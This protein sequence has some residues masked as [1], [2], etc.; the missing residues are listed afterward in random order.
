MNRACVNLARNVRA[1]ATGFDSPT[2]QRA[3]EANPARGAAGRLHPQPPLVPVCED[4]AD[5]QRGATGMLASDYRVISAGNVEAALAKA[6]AEP[7]DLVVMDL[8]MRGPGGVHLITEMRSRGRLAQIPVIVLAGSADEQSRFKLPAKWVQ[9]Y[10]TKPFSEEEVRGRVGVVMKCTRDALQEELARQSEDLSRLTEELIGS[11]QALKRSRK[12]ARQSERHLR[13][14]F[15]NSVTGVAIADQKGHFRAVNRACQ[16]MFGYSQEEL[17]K[18]TLIDIT[19]EDDKESNRRILARFR[20]GEQKVWEA[21]NRYYRKDGKT[22]WGNLR[23]SAIPWAGTGPT[24][25]MVSTEDIT[26]RKAAEERLHECE[27][28]VE[29]VQNAVVVIDREYRYVIANHVFLTHQG[30]ER[31][32]VLG[33]SVGEFLDPVVFEAVVRPRLDECFQGNVVKYELRYRYPRL[34]ERDLLLSYFPIEGPTRVDQVACIGEDITERKAAES[35]MQELAGWILRLEDEERGRMAREL[36][37]GT[38]QLLSALTMNLSVA[39]ESAGV[40]NPRARRA[41]AES[42]TLADECLREVRTVSYLLHSPELDELGLPSTLARYVHGFVHRS[43]IQVDFEVS[44]EFG[45]LPPEVETTVFRT[46]QECL[47]NVHRHSG[48]GS[49]HIRLI[50]GPSQIILEVHD[51]G[52]GIAEGTPSGVG[53]AS[54]RERI[55]QVGGSLQIDLRHDDL[56][57]AGTTVNV[58]VPLSRVSAAGV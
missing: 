44:P 23:L 48:S 56:K 19:H 9:D 27:K 57:G 32:Q 4:N 36:H 13:A 47:T 26:E 7:P 10:I 30:L 40:L 21:E 5:M 20:K 46:V 18:L 8:A 55:K 58:T 33:H 28:V 1:L 41:L 31:E 38:A 15:E 25:I 24:C 54:M 3:T 42:V 16:K 35:S 50:R 52:I 45:R 53:L 29:S 37:D 11:R 22:I 6:I 34:G 17:R 2:P 39:N 12:A 49:A 43:G 14:I 51:A